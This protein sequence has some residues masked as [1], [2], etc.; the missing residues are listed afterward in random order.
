MHST[1]RATIARWA[2]YLVV[3]ALPVIGYAVWQEPPPASPEVQ[4]AEAKLRLAYESRHPEC[5]KVRVA[6]T[7]QTDGSV[8]RT[9]TQ[10][11]D[12]HCGEPSTK[13]KGLFFLGKMALHLL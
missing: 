7:R 8:H 9:E 1:R 5:L 4:A 12:K 6:A 3:A 13:E 10:E 11:F 2:T